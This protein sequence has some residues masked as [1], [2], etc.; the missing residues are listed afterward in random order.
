MKMIKKKNRGIHYFRYRILHLPN[1]VSDRLAINE[2][3]FQLFPDRGIAILGAMS[4]KKAFK[5]CPEDVRQDKI[6][7]SGSIGGMI[8][9]KINDT[10]TMVTLAYG[11]DFGGAIPSYVSEVAGMYILL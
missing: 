3:R 6:C 9:E 4:T 10:T 2:E 11:L 7:M 1:P 5:M 8:F